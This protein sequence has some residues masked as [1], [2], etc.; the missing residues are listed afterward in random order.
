MVEGHYGTITE[1][2]TLKQRMYVDVY[3]SLFMT[4]AIL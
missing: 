4:N 2:R 1:K 3:C